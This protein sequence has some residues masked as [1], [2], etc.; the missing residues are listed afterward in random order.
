MTNFIA[1]DKICN[2]KIKVFTAVYKQ[3]TEIWLANKKRESGFSAEEYRINHNAI[4]KFATVS[5]L[6]L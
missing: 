5:R 2:S 6:F 4:V 1:C 3:I